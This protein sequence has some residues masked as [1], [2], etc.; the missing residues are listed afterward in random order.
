MWKVKVSALCPKCAQEMILGSIVDGSAL[1]KCLNDK[2]QHSETYK[3]TTSDALAK[4]VLEK[5]AKNMKE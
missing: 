3:G 1:V 2:C 5:M 4:S